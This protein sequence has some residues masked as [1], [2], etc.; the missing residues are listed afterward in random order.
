M[1]RNNVIILPIIALLIGALLV[2]LGIY[3]T[4]TSGTKDYVETIGYYTSSYLAEEAYYD[5]D[6]DTNRDATYYLVYEYYV[7]GE[8]YYATTDYSTSFI[9]SLG[10]E[11]EVLYD[12]EIPAISVIGGPSNSNTALILF[13]IFFILCS[14]PFLFFLLPEKQEKKTPKIDTMGIMMGSV[15]A[16]VG[17]GALALICGSFS[18]IGI[19]KYMFSS[20]VLPFAIPFLMIFAGIFLVVKSIFF[21]K[22]EEDY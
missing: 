18:P 20:F 5:A 10:E 7:D 22:N 13:G 12:A 9:P 3:K 11:I 6:T 8:A 4:A 2:G 1:K 16:L 17:Y 19:L 21:Y 15:L 14:A